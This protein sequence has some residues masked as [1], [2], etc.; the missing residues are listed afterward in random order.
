MADREVASAES[1]KSWYDYI[2][3]FKRE[4]F[5][6]LQEHGLTFAEALLLWKM[7]ECYN[8][9]LSIEEVLTASDDD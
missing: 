9:L 8:Q 3:G 1:V 5:P 2:D 7:N 6:I 4:V